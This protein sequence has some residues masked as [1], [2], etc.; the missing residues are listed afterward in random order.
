[1]TEFLVRPETFGATV[2]DPQNLSYFFID[3]GQFAVLRSLSVAR[4]EFGSEVLNPKTDT[5]GDISGGNFFQHGKNAFHLDAASKNIPEII[6]LGRGNL[7]SLL[8][9]NELELGVSQANN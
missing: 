6:F 8:K 3:D 9:G 4:D 7:N 5:E 1:M 2:Y